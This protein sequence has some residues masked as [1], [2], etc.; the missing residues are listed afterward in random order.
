MPYIGR[1]TSFTTHAHRSLGNRLIY[2]K[3]PYFNNGY[4]DA[5]RHIKPKYEEKKFQ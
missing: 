3:C 5:I 2:V 4:H 1:I